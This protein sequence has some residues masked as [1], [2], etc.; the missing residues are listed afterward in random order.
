MATPPTVTLSAAS[1]R[2]VAAAVTAQVISGTY[3]L[4]QVI[5]AM[6]QQQDT[7]ASAG[8]ETSA[9]EAAIVAAL[10]SPA[11]QAA[12]RSAVG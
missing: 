11:G 12:I 6:K 3:T 2:A 9:V 5:V 4:G 10:Q 7:I 8:L 1:V